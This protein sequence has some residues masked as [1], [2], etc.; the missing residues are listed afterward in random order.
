MSRTEICLW[1]TSW[2][3]VSPELQRCFSHLEREAFDSGMKLLK[4][5]ACSTDE[6]ALKLLFQEKRDDYP[7]RCYIEQFYP[8]S[9]A[10]IWFA[11]YMPGMDFSP[12]IK[13]PPASGHSIATQL[14]AMPAR[15][16][17]LYDCFDGIK[18]TIDDPGGLLPQLRMKP[19]DQK[20]MEKLARK[21]PKY[22]SLTRFFDFGNGDYAAYSD[23][24][25][26]VVFD[27][28]TEE[29]K[30]VG[31]DCFLDEMVFAP[32]NETIEKYFKFHK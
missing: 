18:N 24:A 3:D 31:L 21:T 14:T 25:N 8:P 20:A 15:L 13:L 16:R 29:C 10:L 7:V 28:E 9:Y 30:E 4:T 23:K 2:S 17:R 6:P 32:M 1:D 26:V 11:F 22:Q 27:H 12:T 5:R 19:I